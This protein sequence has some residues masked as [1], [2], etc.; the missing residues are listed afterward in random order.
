MA[1]EDAGFL[2]VTQNHTTWSGSHVDAQA[3]S[4]RDSVHS[5]LL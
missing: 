4:Q 3:F 2:I 1:D 5:E